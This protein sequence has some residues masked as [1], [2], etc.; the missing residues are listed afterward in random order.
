[1][2]IKRVRHKLEQ[3]K[4]TRD[5]A[6]LCSIHHI[7]RPKSAL[8]INDNVQ[9][10]GTSEQDV[11]KLLW[12]IRANFFTFFVFTAGF[13]NYVPIASLNIY[14][15]Y[16]FLKLRNQHACNKHESSGG[17]GALWHRSPS[18]TNPWTAHPALRSRRE[19][20]KTNRRIGEASNPGPQVPLQLKLRSANV[21]SAN[22][23]ETP[24]LEQEADI[25]FL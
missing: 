4:D 5:T 6:S 15:S 17:S 10:R 14:L 7:R 16:A 3:S 2:R 18:W 8:S 1:M 12:E 13:K 9:T 23:N 22:A 25:I 19:S 24:T 21:T 11:D 20:S